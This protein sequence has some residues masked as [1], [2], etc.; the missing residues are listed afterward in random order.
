ME[1]ILIFS[2]WLLANFVQSVFGTAVTVTSSNTS[3]G[4]VAEAKS[5]SFV[6][7]ECHCINIL[8]NLRL[9]FTPSADSGGV[10]EERSAV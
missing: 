5:V 3:P 2:D 9:N 8:S 6:S 1:R 4:T 7:L 10:T